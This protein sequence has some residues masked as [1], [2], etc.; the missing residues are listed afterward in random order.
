MSEVGC[1]VLK[2]EIMQP[3]G[4]KAGHR[5]IP[6]LD[7][8][9]A[10]SVG[11]VLVAHAGF[12]W[13]VPGGLGVTIFF[14]LSGYLITTLL[15]SEHRRAGSIDLKAFYI[16]RF[17]RLSPALYVTLA[18]THVLVGLGWLGGGVSA[19]GIAAQMLY[20]TNYFILFFDPLLQQ[21]PG[22]TSILWSLAVEEHF[23]LLFPLALVCALRARRSPMM[24]LSIGIAIVCLAVLIWRCVLIFVFEVD[25]LRTYYATDTRIDAILFGCL[26]ASISAARWALPDH[27][28][29]ER[30]LHTLFLCGI[31]GILATL[32]VRNAAFRETLRYSLQG[33][34]L[35]P[36][37]VYLIS[38]P[39]SVYG[40]VLN[41]RV[42][43]EIGQRSYT[44]YL[45]HFVISDCL[46]HFFPTIGEKKFVLLLA[47]CCGAYVYA[48]VVDGV[49]D[50]YLASIR[51]KFHRAPSS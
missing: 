32:L 16:R 12:G 50:R 26:L 47:I 13:A 48:A 36:I 35:I 4:S 9:R 7:G 49:T 23:Y 10:I 39:Q 29:L 40:Q 28:D 34:F 21:I 46:T 45:S 20:F 1:L 18:I 22:G 6:S 38:N 42:M 3:A 44:I 17:L 19:A 2:Q 51:R 43:K 25:A 15:I 14:F 30:R 37:F 11:L 5:S 24:H 41:S 27:L 31:V 8:I 33:L